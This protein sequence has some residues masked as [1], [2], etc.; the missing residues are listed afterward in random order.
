MTNSSIT[1]WGKCLPPTVLTNHDLEG[2]V[3]T[4]DDWITSRTGIKERRISHVGT[5]ELATLAGKRALAAA[6]VAATDVDLVNVATCT[7]DTLIPSTA[8]LVQ[9]NLGAT[10]AGAADQNAA[11]SGFLYSLIMTCGLVEAGVIET[12]LV[13]GAERLTYFID[14]TDRGTA[15]LF[16]DGAGAV[17]VQAT[18]EPG[19]LKGS[20]MGSDGSVADILWSPGSGTA[21]NRVELESNH[22][23][24]AVS[25][26]GPEV[27]KRA[28]TAMGDGSIKVVDQAG[29]A[30]DDVDILI[31]HQANTRIIDATARRLQ[32]DSSRVFVNIASY[33]NT[34]AATIPIALTEALEMGRIDPGAKI[35]FAAFGG[36]LS[37]AAAAFEFG[38]RV[39]PLAEIDDELPPTDGD[40]M[41]LLAENFA[42]FGGGPAQ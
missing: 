24:M 34:S 29:W 12:G 5:S 42:Y 20:E 16:G 26:N 18:D 23:H 2:L 33:G 3:D 15:V 11:C 30:F 14:F 4:N 8:S 41:A 22:K 9:N 10:N 13:I 28:V 39:T 36:G 31:P 7:P 25:M 19:G 1:G 6:G 27:F 40:V 37:W 21:T 17:V 32:L 35:V 38:S